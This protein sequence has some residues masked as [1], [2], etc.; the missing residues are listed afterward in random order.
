MKFVLFFLETFFLLKHFDDKHFTNW[1]LTNIIVQDEE[2]ATLM[3]L[4][5][6]VQKHLYLILGGGVYVSHWWLWYAQCIKFQ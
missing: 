2:D 4:G 5:F 6:N 3:F 1:T